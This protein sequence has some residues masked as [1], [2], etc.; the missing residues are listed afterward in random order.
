MSGEGDM[1][2]CSCDYKV[3]EVMT[4]NLR[5]ETARHQIAVVTTK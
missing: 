4:Y 1:L 5:V 2:D 3:R